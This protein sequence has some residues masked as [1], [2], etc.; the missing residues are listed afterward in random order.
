MGAWDTC[1]MLIGAVD[2]CG[3]TPNRREMI[4]SP[5][6][7]RSRDLF[8]GRRPGGV[9]A[10]RMELTWKFDNGSVLAFV[11]HDDTSVE[12]LAGSTYAFMDF[13]PDEA[14]FDPEVVRA[15]RRRI[16]PW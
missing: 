5:A 10:N 3:R 15:L 11:H 12:R 2:R 16:Y 4:Y 13:D 1:T 14:Y 6:Y 7:R 9:T 8:G